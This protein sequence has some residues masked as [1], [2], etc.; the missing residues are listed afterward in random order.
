MLKKMPQQSAVI[1]KALHRC[2]Y[3]TDP[4]THML[5]EKMAR[6]Y[7]IY[8]VELLYMQQYLSRKNEGYVVLNNSLFHE[9]QEIREILLCLFEF[10]LRKE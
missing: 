4:T 8:G 5:F 7:I 1:I 3:A 2:K 6:I 10:L 9:I